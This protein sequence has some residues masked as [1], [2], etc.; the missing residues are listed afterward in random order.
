MSEEFDFAVIG[1]GSGGLVV[2]AAAAKLGQRVVLFEKDR[3]GGECLNTGCVP[4]KALIAAGKAAAQVGKASAFGVTATPRIDVAAVRAHVRCTITAIAPHDSQG[5]MEGLGIR[6]VRAAARFK[7][8]GTLEASGKLFRARRIVI[9]CGSRPAVPAIPGLEG[10][11]YLTNG[12]LFDLDDLPEHLIV[13]GGG[14]IGVEMAQA[15]ARLGS[16]V[17]IIEAAATPLGREDG[18][19]VEVVV[20]QLASDG[21]VI[22]TNC[23][24]ASVAHGP[25]GFSLVLADGSTV[26]GSHLLVA[27][28][29][30]PNLD[31]LDLEAAGIAASDRGI[32]VDKR[33]RTT[34]TCV[35]AIGDCAGGPQFAHAATHQAGLVIRHALFRLPVD[36]RKAIVPR[37]SYCEPELAQAGLTESEARQAFGGSITVLRRSFDGN[38]RSVAEGATAGFVKIVAG[39]GGRILG[40]GIVGDGAGD[41]LQPWLVAMSNGLTLRD[42]LKVVTP[43]PT[44]SELAQKAAL[45]YYAGLSG[46]RW[47]RRAIGWLARIG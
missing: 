23:R 16:A 42:M 45:D 7:D 6:V 38:D 28:G 22:R 17:T 8:A 32:T 13:I 10:T 21:V 26:V 30:R 20:D 47:V 44:H 27:T 33:M 43:Y 31:G 3:M 25:D 19:L 24:I 41:L 40:V 2:A 36:A 14:P 12:N 15:H 9:A 1:A 29:R 11:P 34:N 46:N 35:Y 18:E 39:R 5:R 37:V 4:S